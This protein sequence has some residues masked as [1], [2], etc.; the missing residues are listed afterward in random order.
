MLEEVELYVYEKYIKGMV[1]EDNGKKKISKEELDEL[2]LSPHE[3]N[4]IMYIINKQKIKVTEEKITRVDRSPYVR[5]NNYGDIKSNEL[6]TKDEPV[7][8]KVEYSEAND[9]IYEDYK[10]LDEYLET[11][12][13]PNYV[14]L[15]RK[16]NDNGEVEN[17][18]SIRLHHI[19]ALRLSEAELEHVMNYLKERNIRVGGKG[20]TLDKEFENYDYVTTYKESALPL[21]VP[22]NVTIKKIELYKQ[23]KEQKLR[24][25]IITD[26]MRLVPYVAYRYAMSTGINQHELESYGYEELILALERFDVSKGYTFSTYAVA[27]IRKH[28]LNGI[29]EIL[30]GKRDDFYDDYV[31]AKIAVE[32]QNGVTLAEDPELVE[33]VIDLLVAAGKIKDNDGIKEQARRKITSMAIGNASLDDE[34]VLEELTTDGYLVDTHDYAEEVLSTMSRETLEKMLDTLTEREAEVLRLRFGFYDGRTK[35][36]DEVA[37]IFGLT[38]ERIRQIENKAI[39]KLRHPSRAKWLRD[40]Y[41]DDSETERYG[42]K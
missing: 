27:C 3:K 38:R 35:T 8:A 34:E 24:E 17:F 9:K 13:I 12:F 14:L 26:N 1:F 20:A 18:P 42:R 41:L 39:R 4:F 33:D 29:K 15:K 37:E 19:M 5:D 10:E 40:F 31:E 25:E 28:I 7:M 23:N 6:Q 32:K 11:R 30:L 22:A 36:L 21:S 16:K 2:K